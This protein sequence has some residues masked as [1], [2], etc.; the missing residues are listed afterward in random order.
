MRH[1]EMHSWLQRKGVLLVGGDLDEAPQ[2]YRRL[3]EV[4]AEHSGTIR[5]LHTFKQ[6]AWLWPAPTCT[7]PIRISRALLSPYRW[8]F[9]LDRGQ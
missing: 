3:P 9:T 7:I 6:M 5:I 1:D 4:L 8:S 2:A